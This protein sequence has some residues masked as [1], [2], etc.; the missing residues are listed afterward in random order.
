MPAKGRAW[1]KPE[2]LKPSWRTWTFRHTTRQDI[3]RDRIS[4]TS[5]SG[6]MMRLAASLLNL[7]RSPMPNH[8]RA[9]ERMRGEKE[10]KKKKKKKKTED[11]EQR[12]KSS[13]KKSPM[14]I[15]QDQLCLS[16]VLGT[17]TGGV[18]GGPSTVPTRYDE[19]ARLLLLDPDFSATS[20]FINYYQLGMVDETTFYRLITEMLQD[21]RPRMQEL[22]VMALNATPSF[23][24][25]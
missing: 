22:G 10:K 13:Q 24:S 6:R 18:G 3:D 12:K 16:R 19:W 21:P 8:P 20:R 7:T 17:L 5:K 11:L 9:R 15:P 25:L 4:D 1:Q 2:S 23:K 14:T